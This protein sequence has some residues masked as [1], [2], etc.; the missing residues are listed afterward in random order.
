VRDGANL[1]TLTHYVRASQFTIIAIETDRGEVFGSF[2]STPWRN[3]FG[4]FGGPPAFVWKMRSSRQT[5]CTSLFEQARLESQIDV[6]PYSGKLNLVQVCRHSLL[7]VGGDDMKDESLA[8]L[9]P[10]LAA[11]GRISAHRHGFAFALEEDLL[12]GTTSPCSTFQSPALCGSSESSTVFFTSGVEVWTLTPSRDVSSAEKMELAQFFIEQS[13]RSSAASIRSSSLSPVGPTRASTRWG[14]RELNQ[15]DFFRR[16]GHDAQSEQ[17]R[18]LWQYRNG[19]DGE[20]GRTASGALGRSPR[21]GFHE[22]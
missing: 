19:M 4:F 10:A 12:K 5:K 8:R 21:F 7:A 16:V 14:S 15:E 22:T 2:T 3:N 20:L 18:Q 6:Y 1:E 17:R 9:T 11:K 13:T